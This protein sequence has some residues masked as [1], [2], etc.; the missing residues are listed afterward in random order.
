D[1]PPAVGAAHVEDLALAAEGRLREVV[2][3]VNSLDGEGA[4][5]HGAHD[6]PRAAAGLLD[7]GGDLERVSVQV[8]EVDR[9][10]RSVVDGTPELD[11]ER[12]QMFL[13]RLEARG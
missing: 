4:V 5:R 12:G 2:R 9:P 7:R 11:A 10:R 13:G 3:E 6:T 1:A 8:V